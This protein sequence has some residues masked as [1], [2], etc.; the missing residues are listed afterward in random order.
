MRL[1]F[2]LPPVEL[3]QLFMLNVHQKTSLYSF[4]S[5]IIV[6]TRFYELNL[7]LSSPMMAALRFW[8]NEL[9]FTSSFL[10]NSS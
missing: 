5:V 8:S 7:R 6:S 9:V 10:L 4:K 2:T 1:I 3:L